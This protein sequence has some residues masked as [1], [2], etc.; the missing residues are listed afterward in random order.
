MAHDLHTQAAADRQ[1]ASKTE[2][3]TDGS[4][5]RAAA[6]TPK[7]LAPTCLVLAALLAV[8]AILQPAK[9]LRVVRTGAIDPVSGSGLKPTHPRM[10]RSARTGSLRDIELTFR[11]RASELLP[12]ENAFQTA[13]GETGLRAELTSTVPDGSVSLVLLS[14]LTD[15]TFFVASLIDHF[16]PNRDYLVRIH[17]TGGRSITAWLDG[18]KEFTYAFPNPV[19]QP[20]LD[21]VAV[22][23]GYSRTRPWF[24]NVRDFSLRWANVAQPAPDSHLRDGL[25]LA[26]GLLAALGLLALALRAATNPWVLSWLVRRRPPERRSDPQTTAMDKRL[27]R[28]P[29]LL[30]FALLIAGTAT[31]AAVTPPQNVALKATGA[32]DVGPLSIT[33]GNQSS[34]FLAREPHV[35]AAAAALDVRYSL[36]VRVPREIPPAAKYSPVIVSGRGGNAGLALQLTHAGSLDAVIGA[37]VLDNP[38]ELEL[39]HHMPRG[40]WVHLDAAVLRDRTFEFSMD[41]QQLRRLTFTMRSL[42]PAPQ[43]LLIGGDTPGRTFGGSIRTF[44]MHTT[45]FENEARGLQVGIHGAQLAG[46]LAVVFGAILLCGSLLGRLARATHSARRPLV[47]VTFATV[48]VGFVLNYTVDLFHTQHGLSAY[49]PR[50]TWLQLPALR[51]SDFLEVNGVFR[52]L[53]PYGNQGGSYPP[54]GYWLVAPF[55]WMREYAGLFV[56]LAVAVGFITW[57]AWQRFTPGLFTWE[58]CAVVAMTLVSYPVVFALDRANVDLYVFILVALGITA[59]T[60]RRNGLAACLLGL[61]TGA[62][63]VPGLF[64]LVF[65]RGKRVRYFLLGLLVAAGVNAVALAGFRGQPV[66]NIHGFQSGLALYDSQNDGGINATLGNTSIAG[67]AQGVGYALNADTGAKD[68]RLAIK[69]Y[70]TPLLLLGS[71]LLAWYLARR[72]RTLWRGITLIT[73]AFLLL[74]DVSYEYRL[75]FLLVPLSLFLLERRLTTEPCAS[76]V[77]SGLLLAPRV[78]F[79]PPGLAHHVVRVPQRAPPHTPWSCGDTRRPTRTTRTGHERTGRERGRRSRNRRGRHVQ[80]DGTGAAMTPDWKGIEPDPTDGTSRPLQCASRNADDSRCTAILVGAWAWLRAKPEGARATAA[81]PSARAPAPATVVSTPT[82]TATSLRADATVVIVNSNGRNG[83]AGRT[84]TQVGDLGYR[85]LLPLTSKDHL[86]RTT[87]QFKPGFEDVARQ[88]ATD[89]KYADP[90][91]APTPILPS[92]AGAQT[93]DVVV[94][95][96]GDAPR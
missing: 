52:S 67:F 85:T 84:T 18:K 47:L 35:L 19:V 43:D 11:V 82:S 54:F 16:E 68:V 56:F 83:A 49:F 62:K 61:A 53:R 55:V 15:G 34:Y 41:G 75:L 63:I 17:I 51:F 14:S 22:G 26:A 58:R 76:R 25:L 10:P 42:A 65:L 94:L 30:G 28:R 32:R 57:W 37:R 27:R 89:L 88:L 59:F 66:A 36:D 80:D 50:N 2:P 90:V 91:I 24:G 5:P 3:R 40:R 12:F 44:T 60:R 93:A 78:Y 74:P 87:I 45:T 21:D 96:G 77:S 1:P 6:T 48:L 29:D 8:A 81:R 73:V 72:E 86:A 23:T 38:I 31:L 92:V 4:V 33:A 71:V 46:G 39:A 95:L 13:K 20:R 69:P 7:W 70:L 9:D 64:L 79:L